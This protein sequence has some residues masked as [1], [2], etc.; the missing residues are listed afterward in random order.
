MIKKSK[1]AILK[2]I[3]VLLLISA[4]IVTLLGV[5][6]KSNVQ[7]L[8]PEEIALAFTEAIVSDGNGYSAYEYTLIC[9][10]YEYKD[11]VCQNFIY[12]I[13]YGES[14]YQS[15]MDTRDLK[16]LNDKS[17][18]GEKSKNDDGTLENEVADR[19][20]P[21]YIQLM[22]ELNGW[23]KY[24]TFYIKYFAEL[25]EVREEVFGDRYMTEEIMLSALE[26]NIKAY[27]RKLTGTPEVTEENGKV[28]TPK[29]S[30]L[31]ETKY[32]ENY[33]FTYTVTE[34]KDITLEEYYEHVDE[35]TFKAYKIS[36]EDITEVKAITVNIKVNNETAVEAWKLLV[37]KSDG[38]WY[39]DNT[40]T[41]TATLYN[42]YK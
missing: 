35:A 9:K 24:N 18:M 12:P 33:K 1:S 26:S 11:F 39:V 5:N 37:V 3:V 40:N 20:L 29:V 8:D 16:G 14:H 2:I 19:M 28:Q 13:I 25:L 41:N 34:T 31:Y 32:G 17:Y 15:G 30:G 7:R 23:D 6:F 21:Y 10:N 22:T 36:P 4:T 27:S 42:F 38:K